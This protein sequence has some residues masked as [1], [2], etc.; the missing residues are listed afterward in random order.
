MSA[1]VWPCWWRCQPGATVSCSYAWFFLTNT[2]PTKD[3]L[4]QRQTLVS[5]TQAGSSSPSPSLSSLSPP[6][7]TQACD[8]IVSDNEVR[9][10]LQQ[11]VSLA[12]VCED[13]SHSGLRGS[14]CGI[15]RPLLSVVSSHWIHRLLSRAPQQRT[16]KW[17][18]KGWL[19][20]DIQRM[21]MPQSAY[22][23]FYVPVPETQWHAG[24]SRTTLLHGGS[25]HSGE[26]YTYRKKAV[27][28]LYSIQILVGRGNVRGTGR[29]VEETEWQ[30]ILGDCWSINW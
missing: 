25:S 4:T 6:L 17:E 18:I 29:T 7:P 24:C 23:Y 5:P 11:S 19:A 9:I 26:E 15:G 1:A 2:P 3:T 28:Y 8:V 27:L 16:S 22:T 20:H 12:P 21:T 30:Q 14:S 10:L 13:D